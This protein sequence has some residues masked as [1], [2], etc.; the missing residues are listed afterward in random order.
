MTLQRTRRWQKHLFCHATARSNVSQAV[1]YH[2]W[3]CCMA[4]SFHFNAV[5]TVY[6]FHLN[7]KA[8]GKHFNWNWSNM[9]QWLVEMAL[10]QNYTTI[11]ITSQY[12]KRLHKH[13]KISSLRRYTR[14]DTLSPHKMVLAIK[15]LC[16]RGIPE[17]FVMRSRVSEVSVLT[18]RWKLTSFI[19]QFL[20]V[21]KP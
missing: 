16:S 13:L 4:D 2:A 17:C 10:K 6:L 19:H 18:D 1:S 14:D 8:W 7:C 15:F 21:Q 20:Q 11:Y 3:Y 12:Y 9:Q 5:L